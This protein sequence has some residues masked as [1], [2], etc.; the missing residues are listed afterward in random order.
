M[1]LIERIKD[2]NEIIVSG[3][4]G[5]MSDYPENTLLAFHEALKLG[6]P[7]LE[8]DLRMTKDG[9]LVVI[10]DATVDRTTNGTGEL[11][12]FTLDQ[13][14]KLDA[15]GWKSP[16]F[17][18]LQIPT[19]IEFCEMMLQYPDVL[20]NVEFKPSPVAIETVDQAI[21]ILK[22]YNLYENCVFTSFDANVVAHL[23]DVYGAKTQGFKCEYMQNFVEGEDG[24]YSKMWALAM[25]M[26]VLNAEDV[27]HFREM[28]LQVWCYAPNDEEAV[29]YALS[30]GVYVMTCNN[31]IPGLTKAKQM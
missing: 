9:H 22:K 28:G 29:N 5:F 14:Q 24:T 11:C 26:N 18:G 2:T 15:G 31:P 13:I 4:R 10:H 16:I 20:L 6:V 30:C 23:H 1:N 19:F 12:E 25:A 8:L 21:P 27:K 3:H 7:M 17:K